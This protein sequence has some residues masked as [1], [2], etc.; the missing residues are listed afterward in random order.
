MNER[1]YE[2]V[3]EAFRQIWEVESL[4]TDVRFYMCGAVYQAGVRQGDEVFPRETFAHIL[5]TE[6]IGRSGLTQ[7]ELLEMVER[8][9]EFV[10]VRKKLRPQ[11]LAIVVHMT[12]DYLDRTRRHLKPSTSNGG[13]SDAATP[14][15]GT[16]S[17]GEGEARFQSTEE[18]GEEETP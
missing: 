1:A 15:Q 9:H 2:Q 13:A 17:L 7:T 3:L 8:V 6:A 5:E 18:V 16:P 11:Y 4:P 12:T 14:A 10:L